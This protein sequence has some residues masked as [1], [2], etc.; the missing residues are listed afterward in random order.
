[1]ENF[2]ERISE[3]KR[4]RVIPFTQDPQF[5]IY[6][7]KLLNEVKS[8]VKQDQTRYAG[9]WA[10][11]GLSGLI[12]NVVRKASR[13]WDIFIENKAGKDKLDDEFEDNLMVAIYSTVYY[14]M[15]NDR[16]NATDMELIHRE[17][18][19]HNIE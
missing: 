16:L 14:R 3:L 11:P 13:L 18:H 4:R 5:D 9:D 8:K 15:L 12:F 19:E 2:Q 10:W 1:M 17:Y 6:L 7:E